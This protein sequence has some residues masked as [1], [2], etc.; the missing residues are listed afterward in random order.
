[1]AEPMHGCPG[2]GTQVRRSLLACRDCWRAL[3]AELRDAVTTAWRAVRANRADMAARFVH[4]A[5]VLAALGWYRESREE[6]LSP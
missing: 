6:G 1:M 5:A 4:R 3:P 2:C